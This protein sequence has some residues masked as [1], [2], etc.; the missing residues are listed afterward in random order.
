[1]RIHIQRVNNASV[2][3]KNKT[4]GKID[5]GILILLGIHK[6]DTKENVEKLAKKCLNLRIF[7]DDNDK[8]NLSVLDI[9]GEILVIS[10]FT[11][12]ADTQKGNRPNFMEAAPNNKAKFLYNK[13]VEILKQS[14]LNI[15]EG[16]FGATMEVN[17]SNNGP[18][19]MLLEN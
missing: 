5:N 19:T 18:V 2:S 10:N 16:V 11:L 15:E 17:I 9:K 14:K 12:Y 3:V 4:V 6:N 13:F 1:M 7:N 8:M